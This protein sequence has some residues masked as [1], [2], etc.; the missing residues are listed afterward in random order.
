[1]RSLTLLSIGFVALNKVV[2][3][4]YLV[5]LEPWLALLL[6]GVPYAALPATTPQATPALRPAED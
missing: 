1:M 2:H 5:W 4:N 6:A 3:G